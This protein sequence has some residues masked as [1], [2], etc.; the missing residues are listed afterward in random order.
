MGKSFSFR[1]AAYYTLYI[2]Q[3]LAGISVGVLTFLAANNPTEYDQ[4]P[5]IQS[6]ITWSKGHTL[7]A[8]GLSLYIG[9]ASFACKQIGPPWA[10]KAIKYLTDQFQKQVIK[11]MAHPTLDEHRVTLFKHV[12][13]NYHLRDWRSLRERS[14]LEKWPSPSELWYLT[15]FKPIV[16]SGHVAQH[17]ISWFPLFDQ[18]RMGEGVIGVVWRTEGVKR[19]EDL[20]LC[21][22]PDPTTV[23]Q[24][25]ES[26]ASL[27]RV[28]PVWLK[29]KDSRTK[30]RSFCGIP[31]EANGKLWGAVIIDSRNPKL[32]ITDEHVELTAAALG[33][34][35]EKA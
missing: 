12:R 22:S 16:R 19:I 31:I 7:W 24:A 35:I 17:N 9:A 23:D 6:S 15:W 28:A 3:W 27:V 5:S 1:Y 2:S 34:F 25:I 11:G 8:F 14:G 10:W 30:V 20:P 33:K 29:G 26:Y 13:R 32:T 18:H 21:T 4:W